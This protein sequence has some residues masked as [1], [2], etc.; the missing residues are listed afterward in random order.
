MGIYQDD[1][2]DAQRLTHTVI[3]SAIDDFMSG[4]GGAEGGK[5]VAAWACE[6]KHADRVFAWVKSRSEMRNVRMSEHAFR[7]GAA[8]THIYC[9]TEGHA[10]LHEVA[11]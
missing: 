4:W 11:A 3:V 6:P 7:S 9:V 1:R 10:S 5:S 8:H 2:T